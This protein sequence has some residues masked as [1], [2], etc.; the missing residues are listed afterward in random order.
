MT[1]TQPHVP[2][3]PRGTIIDGHGRPLPDPE[4]GELR[5]G[6]FPL[7]ATCGTCRAE[8][9]CG[10]L[11][12]GWAHTVAA[13]LHGVSGTVGELR[14]LRAQYAALLPAIRALADLGRLDDAERVRA[15][16]AI[17]AATLFWVPVPCVVCRG[18]FPVETPVGQAGEPGSVLCKDCDEKITAYMVAQHPAVVA[19]WPGG[20]GQAPATPATEHPH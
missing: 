1:D 19:R 16:A 11:R 10:D 9:A 7:R 17:L 6:Q 14:T 18:M 15:D 4:N 8:I 13:M 3:P 5:S 20:G 12:A 2:A